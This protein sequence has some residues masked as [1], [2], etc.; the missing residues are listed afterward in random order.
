MDRLRPARRCPARLAR[1]AHLL[2][3]LLVVL[4]LAVLSTLAWPALNAMLLRYRADALQLSLHASLS[5]AR[6]RALSERSLVG[7]CASE[8]GAT[9][10][11]AWSAVWIVY[12]SG[13]RRA[14]PASPADVL[15]RH[16]GRADITVHAQASSG[17]PLLFFQPDGRSPGANLTLRICAGNRLHGR[18]VVN[19]GGRTR[20]ERVVRETPC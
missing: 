2:E 20:S 17:R 11:L 4:L 14:P 15:V 3:L 10:S 8:D 5:G 13:E 12:R 19:N 18:L 6:S 1:G 7:L 9:C 16:R